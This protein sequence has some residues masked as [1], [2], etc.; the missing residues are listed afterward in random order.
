MT[1][2]L[3]LALK[4]HYEPGQREL[5]TL[6]L[7]H[8]TGGNED[9]LLPL[10]RALLPGAGLLSPRG[11]VLEHGQPRFFKRLAEGVFDQQDLKL[12]TAELALFLQDA[13]TAYGYDPE[14]VVAVGF[15]NGANI[16]SSLM[17]SGTG[18]L[19]SAVLMRAMVPFEPASLPRLAGTPVLISAG[20][21]DPIVPLA[22]VERLA[23]LFRESGAT[24]EVSLQ[25]GGH[26]LTR[27]D[28]VAATTFLAQFAS[29]P[30]GG[31]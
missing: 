12:R 4:H 6:L 5:P 30:T 10:G 15:S 9:S 11:G 17:L 24:V 20:A 29:A 18:A 2:P 23:T 13:A 14:R 21:D 26:S 31:K 3:Q 1:S 22:Q 8:G 16:A 25:P 28:I 27:G 19:S 7:L